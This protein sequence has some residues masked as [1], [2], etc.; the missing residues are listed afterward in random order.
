MTDASG[1][2]SDAQPEP[3]RRPASKI[4]I[5]GITQLDDALLAEQLG[6]NFIG[7]IFHKDSPRC[8][9]PQT[10][11][12][13]AKALGRARPIGV[14]VSQT[15]AEVAAI[16]AQVGLYGVQVYARICLELPK[17]LIKIQALRVRDAQDLAMIEHNSGADFYLL[18]RY[19]HQHYGGTGAA[20]DWRILPE[21]RGNLFIAGGINP[22]NVRAACALKP[23]AI[24]VASGVEAIPGKKD[25]DKLTALFKEI[26]SCN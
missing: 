5:C 15:P 4:K 9:T 21:E 22:G 20:F 3:L 7:L 14:F 24:D 25:P 19:H 16:A 2:I 23:Y 13:I 6:A 10:A 1:N 11:L 17:H 8:V 18:D 26:Q 12:Q